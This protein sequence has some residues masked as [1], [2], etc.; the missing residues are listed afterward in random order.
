MTL[1]VSAASDVSIS[2]T[3]IPE[4]TVTL[5]GQKIE[6]GR[7]QF[8]LLVYKD[9]T[10]V[11]MTYHDCRFLGL[12]T[13]WNDET[14][15][16]SIEKTNIT[17]AYRDYDI[18]WDTLRN[19]YL[20]LCNFNIIV[21]GKE[22]DNSK[23][24][25]PLLTFRDVTYFP[26]TWRFAVE[27]FGWEYS[28]DEDDGL[29]INSS[30][31]K[32]EIINLPNI[33]GSAIFDGEY[34]YYNGKSGDTNVIYAAFHET[35]DDAYVIHQL[36]DTNLSRAASFIKSSDGIYITYQAGTS[37]VMSTKKFYKLDGRNRTAEE[38]K[39]DSYVYS[40]HG[41]S[42]AGV[43]NEEITVFCENPYFDSATKITYIKGGTT[44]EMPELPGRV[45]V[46][47]RSVNGKYYDRTPDNE[48]IK[49]FGDKIYF[50]AYDYET[51]GYES[52]IYAIDTETNTVEKIIDKAEGAFYVYSGWVA[53]MQPNSTMIIYG[54]DG[55]LYRYL[56]VTG[57][58]KKIYDGSENPD[59]V[60]LASRGG[61]EIY[62][63][64]KTLDGAKT[65]VLSSFGAYGD[66]LSEAKE[67]FSTNT[68][69]YIS[70]GDL[71]MAVYTAGE[72]PDDEVRLFVPGYNEVSGEMVDFRCSDAVSWVTICDNYM[73][74]GTDGKVVR[75][76][77]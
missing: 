64:M 42:E 1:N 30:N 56:E 10:Y 18:D 53:A 32:T 16:L 33:S 12:E 20:T 57:I 54:K 26:L 31:P 62:V 46:G 66:G 67:I 15:T 58:S 4:F 6:N 69:T 38:K 35:I 23:E 70:S 36:P 72:S 50:M 40:A 51:A 60:V 75:V 21:N 68:G 39:P 52:A 45:R 14:K 65:V 7:R 76:N 11:P 71:V 22:V 63:C 61:Y 73:L 29:I 5:N 55:S 49:I 47:C 2:D 3:A 28:F 34:Y 17:C 44:Y 48:C 37:P 27:E 43:R 25:Y 74:Y 9:I 8:P 24:E 19:D 59:M 41:Y 77:L 13:A